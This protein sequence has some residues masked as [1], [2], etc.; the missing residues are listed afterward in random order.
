MFRQYFLKTTFGLLLSQWLVL[1]Q[2]NFQVVFADKL[3][4]SL[5]ILQVPLIAMLI[6]VA[7]YNFDDDKQNFDE[8]ARIIYYF[9][10][11]KEP[12]KEANQMININKLHRYAKILALESDF[13]TRNEYIQ[14][15]ITPFFDQK[16][17]QISDLDLFLT[18]KV[19]LISD[20]ASM[21]RGSVYFLLVYLLILC[22]L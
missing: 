22:E 4:L 15:I 7:F 10:L 3:N 21:R 20:M 1:I 11:M 2:R 13:D 16:N 14:K 6:I 8:A 12:L 17:V 19:K 18:E 9:D 5:M